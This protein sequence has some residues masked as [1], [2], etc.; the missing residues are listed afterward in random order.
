MNPVNNANLLI[1]ENS[2][3]LL[4]HAHNP[5]QWYPWGKMAFTKAKS[6]DKP[7]FLSIGYASCYWCHFMEKD[8]FEKQDVADILN[9]NFVSIKVDK[10]ERPE[11]DHIYMRALLSFKGSGGWPVSAFLFPDGT[12]FFAE[13]TIMHDQFLHIMREIIKLWCQD[14][15]KLITH[16]NRIHH[17]L[18]EILNPRSDNTQTQFSPIPHFTEAIKN[19]YDAVN[20]GFGN[21]PKF[22]MPVLYLTAI[23]LAVM[24]KDTS[25][26]EIIRNS[27]K[28]II[29]G[30]IHDHVGGGFHRYAVDEHWSVPHFEKMLYDNTLLTLAF[31][32]FFRYTRE[33]IFAFAARKTLDWMTRE[34]LSPEGGFYSAIDAGDFKEEGDF[35]VWKKND[36]S[37]ILDEQ[38]FELFTS[39]YPVSDQGN[40]ELQ[41]NVLF[42]SA[43]LNLSIQDM[44]ELSSILKKLYGART[45]RPFPRLDDKILTEQNAL[46]ISAFAKGGVLLNEPS[47]VQTAKNAMSFIENNLVKTDGTL[48]RNYRNQKSTGQAI[49]NDYAYLIHALFDLHSADTD[50]KWLCLA[51]KLQVTQDQLFFDENSHSYFFHNGKDDTLAYNFR[52]LED[53]VMPSAN[54]ISIR[55]LLNLYALTFNETYKQKAELMMTSLMPFFLDAPF[56]YPGVLESFLMADHTLSSQLVISHPIPRRNEFDPVFSSYIPYLSI[57]HMPIDDNT[58][59]P[60][61]SHKPSIKNEA[62]YYLCC[63]GKCLPPEINFKCIL[64][65][66]N[67]G[68]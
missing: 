54:S 67:N 66:I 38:E 49:L 23:P 1:H 24:Q 10:E 19:R 14:R 58:E 59:F 17:T 40:F 55:N 16:K 45:R 28:A 26:I 48:F 63:A 61:L 42:M 9:E 35:Y 12:P 44:N 53:S 64:D 52:E 57:F 43:S 68:F 65:K 18:M 29:H 7:I 8:S 27:L 15:Q 41:R 50:I 36:I 2:P 20:G 3:Y 30:G 13:S 32:D 60:L 51:K 39:F 11:V 22:P 31:L 46:A 47:Y 5:I 25:L 6:E 33:P 34:M 21:A 4:Q 37:Q 62:T 56:H